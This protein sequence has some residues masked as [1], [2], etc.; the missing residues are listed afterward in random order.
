[1]KTR[2]ARFTFVL[3]LGVFIALTYFAVSTSRAGY[4][5]AAYEVLE[6]EGA[7]EIRRYEAMQVVATKMQGEGQNSSFRR[8]FRYISG[9]NDSEEKIAMTTPVFMPADGEGAM[10]E[11]W[12]VVPAGVAKQGA[13]EPGDES[14]V[15][16][17]VPGGKF[18]AL[19]YSGRSSAKDRRER[20][21]EL[22]AEVERRGLK[23]AG[24]PVFAGYDPPWT[25]GPV[26]R[27]EVLLPLR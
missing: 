16:R 7:F 25:P 14:V 9:G 15:L 20:L 6:R 8:L 18:A 13:P 10:E 23:A 24:A 2:I 4:E 26:R 12:F 3:A 21:A 1:M 11:M 19:R 17:S 5:T 22:R 27:N